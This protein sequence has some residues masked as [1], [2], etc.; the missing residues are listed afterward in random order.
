[1]RRNGYVPRSAVRLREV[2]VKLLRSVRSSQRMGLVAM[3]MV[4]VLAAGTF[5]V[6]ADS[7]LDPV[8]TLPLPCE[9]IPNNANEPPRSAHDIVHVANRCGFVGT[10]IEFQSRRDAQQKVRDYAFVGTMGYGLQI[11]DITDPTNPTEAGGYGTQ[12]Y[13]ND[14]QVRGDLAVLTFDGV[15]GQPVTTSLCLATNYP[16]ANGQGIDLY[17][18]NFD[19]A[20]ATFDV[21]LLTCVANPPGGA[22]N[23]TIN[24]KGSW[25]AI[26][27][28]SSD[29]AIDVVDI[30][31]VLSGK[32]PVHRYRLI[33]SSR[34]DTSRCPSSATFECI[35]VKR[36]NGKPSNGLFRPHDAHF[37][38]WGNVMFVAA[39]NSTFIMNVSDILGGT[40]PTTYSIIPNLSEPGGLS[41]PRNIELSHQADVT[42]D[43]HAL[44]ISDERG[45]GITNTGCNE[46]ENGI[47]GGL[48]FWALKEIPGIPQSIGA[49]LAS[50]RKIGV[51]FY[52]NP[53]L[54]QDVLQPVIEQLP[55][56]ERGCTAHVFRLGENGSSSPGA[57]KRGLGG[58]SSIDHHQL[59]EGWYGAGTW[60]IDFRTP[61][62]NE[63]GTPEDERTTWGNTLGW[64]VQPG[65]ETWSA[66]EY[67][68][69]IYTGDMLRGMDV[70]TF[71]D[72]EGPP[73]C[74][75]E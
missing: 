43:G 29:W 10:D 14:V 25:I 58:V 38:R 2:L 32:D 48:H 69:Y 19:P 63:D 56:T 12:G 74:V 5:V 39:L 1:M 37:S 31:G 22:H 64:N 35:V 60:H 53:L 72:C 42:S 11:W 75:I 4:T 52:P 21:E 51:Y 26:S 3:T 41:N 27:N 8:R 34:F 57:A 65:A 54:A 70:F 16:T 18:L 49:T 7:P 67:K 13:Q 36:P 6:I 23:S 24:P 47:I 20:S 15:S 9:E 73:G 17:R 44:V 66:K 30:R 28:S 59:V 46:D 71:A 45:G 40:V 50:P 62:T 68:G 61:P 33:D 55:R